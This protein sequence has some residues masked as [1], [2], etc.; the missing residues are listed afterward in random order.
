MKLVSAAR[1]GRRKL[2]LHKE[3]TDLP[4]LLTQAVA[5]VRANL[6]AK[7][8]TLEVA[9]RLTDGQVEADPTCLRNVF[10]QLLENVLKYSD[11]GVHIE[12]RLEETNEGWVTVSVTDNGWGI[13]RKCLKKLF[14]EYYQVPRAEGRAQKGYGIGLTYARYVVRAHGG[15]IRVESREGTGSTFSARL[16]RK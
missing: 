7:R 16:P 5:D 15:D 10:A 4:M 3:L 11:E 2:V 14:G 6:P 12:V 1:G 8:Y 13:P 9:N